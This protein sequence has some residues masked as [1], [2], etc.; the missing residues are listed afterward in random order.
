MIRKLS[1][2]KPPRLA[3]DYVDVPHVNQLFNQV[4]EIHAKVNEI[5]EFLA[6]S[7]QAQERVRLEP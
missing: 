3:T 5:I 6:N 4:Q 7:P 1:D 2:P